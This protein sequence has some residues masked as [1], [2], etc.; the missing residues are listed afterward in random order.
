M[1]YINGKEVVF[2]MSGVDG[3]SAY[4]I[5]V[6]HGFE[7]TEE[8][9]LASLKAEADYSF[10]K[11]YVSN[12][13]ESPASIIGGTWIRVENVFLLAAGS[14]YAAGSTGGSADTV[15]IKHTHNINS[16]SGNPIYLK[17]GTNA[18]GWLINTEALN[19]ATN[20][21]AFNYVTN[22]ADSSW[23]ITASNVGTADSGTGKNMPPYKTFYMWERIA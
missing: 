18:S 4:E 21:T 22:G 8:E 1:A 10:I 23:R 14:T 9:W 11:V 13:D 3:E 12:V 6:R 17:K 20:G 5:A 7:G 16:S 2:S 19:N 15:L